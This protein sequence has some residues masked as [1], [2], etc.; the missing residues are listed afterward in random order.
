FFS[1]IFFLILFYVV[2]FFFLFFDYSFFF[3]FQ[4]E[5]GIRDVAVTGVQTC[6]F[7]SRRSAPRKHPAPIGRLNR[8]SAGCASSR[9]ATSCSSPA[10][11]RS[12]GCRGGCCRRR[13]SC[14]ATTTSPRQSRRSSRRGCTT[15]ISAARPSTSRSP[16]AASD[17]SA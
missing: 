1:S 9:G 12:Y 4:A 16:S 2:F 13:S 8:G 3:F 5:D 17:G 11:R 14:S 6:A 7:R 15:R 10:R